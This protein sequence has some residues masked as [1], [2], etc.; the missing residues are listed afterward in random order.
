MDAAT[1]S[2][3]EVVPLTKHIGAE[4]RGIDLRDNLDGETVKAIRKAW[5]DH[6]VLVFRGQQFGQEELVRA[7][8][9]FGEIGPLSRPLKYFPKGYAKLLPN[10]M[11][12][13][14]IRENGETIGALPDG[15]MNFHHDM[16]HAELPHNGTLLYSVEIPTYGGDT[17]FASGYA[18]Y[19][20]L[21]PAIRARLEGR[22]A[23]NHYNYGTTIRGDTSKAVQAF[24]ESVHPVFR[25]HDE[26]GRKAIYV[27]RLMSMKIVDMSPEESDTLLNAVFDHAEKREFVYRH[28]WRV[29]DLLVWDNRCSSHAR[30]DFPSDQR[31]LMLRTTVR[32]TVR[33]Y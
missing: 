28:V 4:I 5:L 31:R 33:P 24:N 19:D 8:G 1:T 10:I 21:D 22:K 12:I 7:T 14:N 9:Y 27:D 32:G 3:L 25:T 16:I 23:L 18:A 13:S 15:E 6:L 17:L 26:T 30:D 2:R 29:G 11:M 20:T